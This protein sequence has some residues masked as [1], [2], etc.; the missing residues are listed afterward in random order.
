MVIKTNNKLI[1]MI[2]NTVSS[3]PS[4]FPL[5][6]SFLDPPYIVRDVPFSAFPFILFYLYF[7]MAICNSFCYYSCY[8]LIIFIFYCSFYS[9]YSLYSMYSMYSGRGF[10]QHTL[11]IHCLGSTP[12]VGLSCSDSL[13]RESWKR[14]FP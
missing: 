14:P 8:F 5:A 3:L 12:L 9:I 6:F 2:R 7:S 1:L 11:R 13:P 10:F 4:P